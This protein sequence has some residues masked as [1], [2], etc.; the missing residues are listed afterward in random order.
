MKGIFV[1]QIFPP[2]A[3]LGYID[4]WKHR[5]FLIINQL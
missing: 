2:I 4:R 1:H 3:E 5:L